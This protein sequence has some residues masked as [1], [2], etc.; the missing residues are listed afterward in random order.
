MREILGV[1]GLVVLFVTFGLLHRNGRIGHRC[2][3]CTSQP[4]GS[5]C[6]SCDLVHDSS[7][8]FNARP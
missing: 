5:D 2:G 7:E 6:A 1:L 8:S 3:P 4:G